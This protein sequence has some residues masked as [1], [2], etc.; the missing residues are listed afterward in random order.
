MM[1]ESIENKWIT[2]TVAL[3]NEIAGKASMP[4]VRCRMKTVKKH[5]RQF[6]GAYPATMEEYTQFYGVY[7]QVGG[8]CRA[9][10]HKIATQTK[11]GMKNGTNKRSSTRHRQ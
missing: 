8:E 4:E 7:K 10:T 11:N 9:T 3:K 1:M 5:I 6:Y 2:A